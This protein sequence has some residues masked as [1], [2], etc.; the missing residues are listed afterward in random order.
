MP[1]VIHLLIVAAIV[2]SVICRGRHMDG[3]TLPI[4]QR[5]HSLL[6][7]AALFSLVVPSEWSAT[8]LGLGEALFMALGAGRWKSGAPEGTRTE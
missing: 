2:W 5:Q 8:V 1:A 6:A 7:A 3:Q 4:V